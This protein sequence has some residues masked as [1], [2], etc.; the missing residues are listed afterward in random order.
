MECAL[1]PSWLTPDRFA[2]LPSNSNWS[3]FMLVAVPSDSPGGLEARISDHFGHCDVFTL[4]RIEEQQ[5]ESV[6]VLPN[7]AHEGGQCMA[8]VMLLKEQGAEALV[9]GGMGQRPLSGFQQVGITVYFKAG[10][11]T[12]RDAVELLIAGQSP[13]FAPAQTC[14]GQ[15]QCESG[16]RDHEQVEREVVDGP[17]EKNRVVLVNFRLTDTDG[18]LI[19]ASDG[20]R[21]LH[22]HGQLLP[23][24]EKVLEGL[25]AGDHAKAT[26]PPE[27]GY[28]DHDESR[29]IQAPTEELPP[30]LAPGATVRAQ[31]PDG[32]SMP[33]TV[34]AI[35][36]PTATLDA[37]HPLAGK[38]LVFDVEVREVYAATA[39]DLT[40]GHIH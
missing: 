23:G 15:G 4:V 25:V 6:E 21:Y 2:G 13:E 37:N 8:P 36:G 19:D 3:S 39:E 31:L 1:L 27:D 29:V 28:G 12:V 26:L 30:G 14:G 7:G 5:V 16:G 35:D 38:T 32:G 9:A 22:G 11:E 33:L 20:V 10:A 17:I 18:E 40:H 34:V 24:L